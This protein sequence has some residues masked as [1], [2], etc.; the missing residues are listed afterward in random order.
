MT[1]YALYGM[2]TVWN[3]DLNA[4]VSTHNE[5]FIFQNVDLAQ[6]HSGLLPKWM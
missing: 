3:N 2:I 1:H 6:Q 5:S 4:S